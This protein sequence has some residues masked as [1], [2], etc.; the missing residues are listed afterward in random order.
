MPN[1]DKLN[2]VLTLTADLV[3]SGSVVADEF[4]NTY[5]YD[6]LNVSVPRSAR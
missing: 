1:F 5:T 6:N 4:V 2:S 3:Q